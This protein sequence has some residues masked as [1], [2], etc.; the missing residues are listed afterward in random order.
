[1]KKNGTTQVT[2]KPGDPIRD[3]GTDW[4]AVAALSDAEVHA[5]AVADPDAQPLPRDMRSL[6]KL[7]NVKKLRERLGLP[8]RT[9]AELYGIP[10]GTLRDWE[11]RRKNPDAP[12]RAYLQVI[13]KSPEAVAVLRRASSLGH[14]L[15]STPSRTSRR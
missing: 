9:F 7:V 6:T 13:E 11:Q 2:R 10:I 12:A 3:T 14:A 8:Q 5:A 4:A 15:L 1:M